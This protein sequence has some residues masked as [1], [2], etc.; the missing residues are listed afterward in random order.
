MVEKTWEVHFIGTYPSL[1]S[2]ILYPRP[3]LHLAP[4]APQGSSTF[5][6]NT[7]YPAETFCSVMHLMFSLLLR[8]HVL[9]ESRL[10]STTLQSSGLTQG[11]DSNSSRPGDV[12]GWSPAVIPG[13]ETPL[14][15]F[16]LP[17]ETRLFGVP[18]EALLEADR[19]A[20]PSTQVPLVLQAVS[21]PQIGLS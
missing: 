9:L 17:A 7:S 6:F 14:L 4:S 1:L 8:P 19:K 5:S 15:F 12:A 16:G 21:C 20:L 2:K 11:K 13:S 3:L 10:S 18:L